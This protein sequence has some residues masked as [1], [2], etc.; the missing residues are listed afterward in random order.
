VN[1]GYEQVGSLKRMRPGSG[2]PQDPG[3]F[4]AFG[5][6]TLTAGTASTKVER[7]AGQDVAEPP[8]GDVEALRDLGFGQVRFRLHH[9][10]RERSGGR[11]RP[12]GFG[13]LAFSGSA[14][15]SVRFRSRLSS[16]TFRCGRD[17]MFRVDG[18]AGFRIRRFRR[19][20]GGV[21]G[22]CVFRRN[23]DRRC[24]RS[25]GRRVVVYGVD[26]RRTFCRLD[27]VGAR[28]RLKVPFL[29]GAGSSR[30]RQRRQRCARRGF[31]NLRR[32]GGRR[33]RSGR[34]KFR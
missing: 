26:W 23:R 22:D 1:G 11:G 21:V 3:R 31:F 13:V 10:L 7:L 28:Y 34:R 30:A 8:G 27:V 2:A 9:A 12:A 25:E 15:L 18:A 6:I 5:R 19:N 24:R 17:W 33:N 4:L 16:G 29:P 20:L 32:F 14:L